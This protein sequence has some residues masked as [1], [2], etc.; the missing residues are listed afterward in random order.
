MLLPAF[1]VAFGK[2]FTPALHVAT[3]SCVAA[4]ADNSWDRVW[5]VSR[6]SLSIASVPQPPVRACPSEA[7]PK[8]RPLF[9]KGANMLTNSGV[10]NGLAPRAEATEAEAP[11]AEAT[12]ARAAEAEMNKWHAAYL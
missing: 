2:F 6:V 9:P 7:M 5:D 1:G 12:D 10:V 8:R 11:E 4:G 3:A